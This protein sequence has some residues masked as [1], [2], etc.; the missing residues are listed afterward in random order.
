MSK[1]SGRSDDPI[2]LTPLAFIRRATRLPIK[3]L[4]GRV[5][6]LSLSLPASIIAIW[7]FMR[8]AAR[9]RK[10]PI[11]VLLTGRMGDL[12]AAEPVIRHIKQPNDYVVWLCRPRY[13]GVLEFNPY[14]DEIRLVTSDFEAALLMRLFSEQRW[15]N[16][17][18]DGTRCNVFGTK[19]KNPNTFGVTIENHYSFG[20]NTGV[21]GLLGAGAKLN[22]RPRL[23]FD[24]S[25]DVLTF[26]TSVFP[27]GKPILVFHPLSD[28]FARSWSEDKAR[29]FADWIL[30]H[31]PFNLIEAGIPPILKSGPRVFNMADRLTLPRQMAVISRAAAFV[32]VDSSFSHMAN[33]VAVPS[34]LLLGTHLGFKTHLP[35]PIH[36]HDI[37]LRGDGQTHEIEVRAVTNAASHILSQIKI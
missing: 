7:R 16:L 24:P 35:L 27:N 29:E 23:Y 11:Y 37:V 10:R 31:T 25:F 5:G 28:E 32:G 22:D 3:D 1:E 33:A 34:V 9:Q 36:E 6:R 12:I 19:L 14:V 17:L 15:I 2:S 4:F 18:L 20:T 30:E 8:C 21:L 13:A 26:I